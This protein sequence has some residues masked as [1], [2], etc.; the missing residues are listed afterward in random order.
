MILAMTL[1]LSF[2]D[3]QVRFFPREFNAGGKC[4]VNFG[5]SVMVRIRLGR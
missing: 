3:H 4:L 5:A 2:Y 1:G